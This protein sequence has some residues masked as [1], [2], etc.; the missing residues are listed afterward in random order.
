MTDTQELTPVATLQSALA[1]VMTQYS[2]ITAFRLN[3]CSACCAL[4]VTQHIRMLLAHPEVQSS[5]TLNHTYR[6]LL[7]EWDAIADHEES[8]HPAVQQADAERKGH[9]KQRLH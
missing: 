3:E 2:M 5:D 6:R 1:Y 8:N 4:T 9:G 7:A